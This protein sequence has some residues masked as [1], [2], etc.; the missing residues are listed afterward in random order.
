MGR[1]LL[2]MLVHNLTIPSHLVG[3]SDTDIN[4]GDGV[5]IQSSSPNAA[6]YM[7]YVANSSDRKYYLQVSV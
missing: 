5:V 4:L 7:V 1:V 6:F 2:D 3:D